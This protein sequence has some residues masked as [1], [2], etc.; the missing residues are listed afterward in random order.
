[1]CRKK[2]G[3]K[4]SVANEIPNNASS[5]VTVT[6]VTSETTTTTSETTTSETITS[7][8]IDNLSN[9]INQADIDL[10]SLHLGVSNAEARNALI[11]NNGNISLAI[12]ELS[13][14]TPF[15]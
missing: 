7:E 3:E 15:H 14:I 4:E 13:D 2:P 12:V 11:R 5:T 1:M 6:I 8:T 10:V 9:R